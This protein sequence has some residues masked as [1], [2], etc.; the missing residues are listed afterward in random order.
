MINKNSILN[1]EIYFSSDKLQNYLVFIST[2][3]IHWIVATVKAIVKM[4]ATVKLTGGNLQECQKVVSKTLILQN[5]A[6]LQ[7][8]LVIISL[9]KGI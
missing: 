9:K 5:L 8:W 4:V 3:R 2:R 1:G 6:L 7:S